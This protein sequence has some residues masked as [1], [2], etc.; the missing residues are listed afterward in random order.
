MCT[1]AKLLQLYATLC[2][3]VNC[4][5]PSLSVHGI[6]QVRILEWV[7][8]PSSRGSS[9]LRN[10]THICV[11]CSASGFFTAEPVGKPPLLL[12]GTCNFSE[13][14]L[15][16]RC[17]FMFRFP[18][19]S[20]LYRDKVM[21]CFIHCSIQNTVQYPADYRYHH[22][23]IGWMGGW[24][25]FIACVISTCAIFRS[26]CIPSFLHKQTWPDDWVWTIEWGWKRGR[27]PWKWNS[28]GAYLC[29]LLCSSSICC[30]V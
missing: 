7:A 16:R 5:L 30:Q 25:G 24:T 11:S 2:N 21:V 17:D 19:G 26:S 14:N 28:S 10:W 9:W 15:C 8:M 3:P 22:I 20:K 6:L 1:C 18:S 12:G 29:R 13:N 27:C 23:L 4:S